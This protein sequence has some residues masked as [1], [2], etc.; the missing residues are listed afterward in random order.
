VGDTGSEHAGRYIHFALSI[1][2]STAFPDAYW[3][4]TALMSHWPL[5]LP[6]HGTVAGFVP[7]DTDLTI[8]AFH[9]RSR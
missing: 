5:R 8:P 9:R 6:P 1:R 3:N 2:P 7:A 4:P